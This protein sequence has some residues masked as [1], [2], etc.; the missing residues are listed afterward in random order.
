MDERRKG[1]QD[2]QHRAGHEAH[3][4]PTERRAHQQAIAVRKRGQ[5]RNSSP[6]NT[7][8]EFVINLKTAK[9]IDL[10]IPESFLLRADDLIE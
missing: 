5:G 1:Q 7:K 8:Y 3:P 6:E 9:A 2:E 10:K 4:A